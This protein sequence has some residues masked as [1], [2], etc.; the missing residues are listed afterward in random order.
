MNPDDLEPAK[1]K[2]VEPADLEVMSIEALGEYIAER[3]A[4]IE[5]ARAAIAKKQAAH[6][7]ASS[8]F[9]Q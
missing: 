9:K 2:T 1:P 8:V 5:R 4:E 7:A 3:E 6:A